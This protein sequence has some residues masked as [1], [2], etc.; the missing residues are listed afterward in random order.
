MDD[1]EVLLKKTEEAKEKRTITGRD[2][3]YFAYTFP[4]TYEDTL[5]SSRDILR[6]A[7][8]Q[9]LYSNREVIGKSLEDRPLELITLTSH[10]HAV[11]GE[12]EKL[13][14]ET[15]QDENNLSQQF[16]KEKK[17]VV[18]LTTRVHCGEMPG[19]FVL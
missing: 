14:E 19:S 10:L 6:R 11:E 3:V 5:W 8:L 18:F 15:E 13:I 9:E 7:K 16:D 12:K 17:K 4:Y 2:R 1:A